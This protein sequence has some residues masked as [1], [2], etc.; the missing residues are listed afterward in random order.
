MLDLCYRQMKVNYLSKSVIARNV[1]TW[2][3]RSRWMRL[4]RRL[5]KRRLASSQWRI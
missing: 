2:Q 5:T 4:P 1:V 3:W